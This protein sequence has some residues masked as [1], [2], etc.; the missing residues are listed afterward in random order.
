MQGPRVLLLLCVL[1]LVLIGLVMVFSASIVKALENGAPAET[2]FR[3]QVIY[4]V[5]G[6]IVALVLWKVVPYHVWIGPLVWIVWGVAVL[7]IFAVWLVGVDH[8]GAQRW[9]A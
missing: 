1:A 6:V 9:L 4:A 5:L 2:F 3:N 8:Y 7:L